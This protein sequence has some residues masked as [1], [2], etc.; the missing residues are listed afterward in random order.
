MM[1]WHC[2]HIF[3]S[4]RLVS[5]YLI[6]WVSL[7]VSSV[8][9]NPEKGQFMSSFPLLQSSAIVLSE[10]RPLHV[11]SI[12]VVVFSSPQ[13][14]DKGMLAPIF[15]HNARDNSGVTSIYIPDG[16]D[17]APHIK[18]KLRSKKDAI[19]HNSNPI[20][21][22]ITGMLEKNN[23][24]WG[25][26]ARAAKASPYWAEHITLAL[27]ECFTTSYAV[28][29]VDFPCPRETNSIAI[30]SYASLDAQGRHELAP[31]MQS[32]CESQLAAA[33]AEHVEG[34]QRVKDREALNNKHVRNASLIK[35]KL[36]RRGSW[37]TVG[38]P[39][40]NPDTIR[41]FA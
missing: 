38:D 25:S 2:H 7:H 23:Y 18:N 35:E 33:A 21:I 9:H 20:N 19:G 22:I 5:L 4:I 10:S 36:S 6:I 3:D 32:F 28:S 41:F 17:Y 29:W 27:G 1:D 37:N 16:F 14:G 39:E 11:D 8:C 12:S 40:G 13:S 31:D 15:S 26:L 24:S 30:T 34:F